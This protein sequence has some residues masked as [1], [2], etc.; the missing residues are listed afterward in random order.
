[1]KYLFSA[2]FLLFVLSGSTQV[3]QKGDFA[4]D[5]G[6]EGG[7]YNTQWDTNVFGADSS[8]A[9]TAAAV[10]VPIHFEYMVSNKIGVGLV[11]KSGNYLSDNSNEDNKAKVYSISFSYHP[12][13]TE[14]IDL[15]AR[16]GLGACS[17]KQTEVILVKIEAQYLGSAFEL[18]AGIKV[19]FSEHFGLNFGLGY[20]NYSFKLQSFT[21]GGNAADLADIESTLGVSGVEVGAGLA[22][23]F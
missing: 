7:Y 12:V 10:F 16:V 18:D 22:F 2:M 19:Y 21:V 15:F 23:K 11:L 8:Y 1:M 4:F 6:I 17:L 14:K 9:D 20:N 13:V 3:V 5:L